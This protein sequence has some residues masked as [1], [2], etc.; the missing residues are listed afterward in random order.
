MPR[1]V[2]QTEA[3]TVEAIR[4]W[5][6][7]PKVIA[8]RCA[9][10]EHSL[11]DDWP[12]EPCPCCGSTTAIS[13]PER[14]VDTLLINTVSGRRGLRS[15]AEDT[16]RFDAVASRAHQIDLVLR[17]S[18]WVCP[19]TGMSEADTL[20]DLDTKAWVFGGANRSGKT[21]L[22]VTWLALRWLLRGGRGALFRIYAPVIKQSHIGMGKLIHGDAQTRPLIDP[23][24]VLSYPSQIRAVD[25]KIRLLDGSEIELMHARS[26]AHIKGES[27]VDSIWLEV[28]E[29]DNDT[30]YPVIQAR[31]VSTRGQL[32]MDST[33]KR[34]H[35][36]VDKVNNARAELERAE[37][38]PG[39]TPLIRA[40]AKPISANP[41]NNPD[42]IAAQ[43]ATVALSD[44]VMARREFDGEWVGRYNL[45]FETAWDGE[46]NT[47]DMWTPDIEALQMGLVDVTRKASRR[48]FGGDGYE[49]VVGVD[50]NKNPNTA[51]ICKIYEHRAHPGIR[52]LLVY[53]QVRAS[54]S[55]YDAAKELHAAP[56]GAGLYRGA[57]I[58]IDANAAHQN[59]H[60]AHTG[61]RATTPI[62][63]YEMFGFKVKTNKSPDKGKP[64][65][66]N[67][68]DS[69][70]LLQHLMRSRI[71]PTNAQVPRLL[72]NASKC[73]GVIR[74]IESQQDRGDNRPVKIPGSF[75][76]SEIAAY[77]D[78]LRYLAWPVF[79]K[80]VYSKPVKAYTFT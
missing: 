4:D 2:R 3:A 50:V 5:I 27:V 78:S 13:G 1:V 73:S 54:G 38:E 65:N 53:D 72:V 47:V 63:D 57:A 32:V 14:Y 61:G 51:V 25:Q 36:L 59:Q 40:F 80:E 35:W 29:C 77:T 31:H 7:R 6:D 55:A 71:G 23:L 76:D 16:F 62:R 79:S 44:P 18:D 42:E 67:V 26:P 74:A 21:Q 17:C 69:T 33:P 30:V 49:W 10:R 43:R 34:G 15:K 46:A 12:G 37:K 28:A 58:A 24:L 64:Y 56:R 60:V 41:W 22:A 48:F 9:I 70:A 39:Y 45:L 68:A 11:R 66:P 20:L 75:S 19:E 52:G 8:V